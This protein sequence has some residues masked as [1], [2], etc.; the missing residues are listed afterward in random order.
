MKKRGKAKPNLLAYQAEQA[1]KEAVAEAIL[2]H[3]RKGIPIVVWRDGKVVEIASDQIEVREPQ[4]EY[5]IF[6]KKKKQ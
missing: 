6:P 5:T 3:K 1:L 2:D 4:A